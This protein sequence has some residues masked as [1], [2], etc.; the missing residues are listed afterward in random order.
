[1]WTED[2]PLICTVARLSPQKGLFD[3]VEAAELMIEQL[4]ELK[5]VVIG[6][7]E[8][9]GRLEA[10]VLKRGL[11]HALFLVGTRPRLQVAEWLGSADLFVLPSRYEG[12]PATALIEAMA[13]GCAVVATN[14]NGVDELVSDDSLGRLVPAQDPAQLASTALALLR[15]PAS[16]RRMRENAQ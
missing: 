5:L 9:R 12:G 15:D 2:L 14:V 16:R 1:P 3:L 8:L 11:A 7:G 6:E 10:E 4:P 13:A